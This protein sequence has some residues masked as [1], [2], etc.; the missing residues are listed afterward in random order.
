MATLNFDASTVDPND[1]FDPIPAGWYNAI[2]DDTEMKPTRDGSGQYLQI[3]FSVIDGEYANRKVFTRLN[4]KNNNP[5]AQEIA[6]KDLSAI[7]RAVNVIRVEDTQQ[8]HGIP[9]MVKVKIRPAQGEWEASNEVSGYKGAN[10][11]MANAQAPAPA[12]PV[13]QQQPAMPAQNA[14]AQPWA[15]APQPAAAV[16]PAPAPQ[17]AAP[18]PAP[19]ASA[20][21]PPP[22]AQ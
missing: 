22:W 4:L 9:L 12:A 19:A 1:S 6:Y 2:I 10:D 18:A 20:S 13:P 15:Q 21:A 5:V 16:A 8:L 7:C 14:P 3:R 17:S 11:G